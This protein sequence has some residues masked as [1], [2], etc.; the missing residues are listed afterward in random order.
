M[1]K[2]YGVKYD[3]SAIEA[4]EQAAKQAKVAPVA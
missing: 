4:Q 1:E 3:L 2:H